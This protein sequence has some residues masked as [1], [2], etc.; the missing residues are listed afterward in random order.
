MKKKL[1]LVAMSSVLALGV[2]GACGDVDEEPINDDP[3]L[4]NNVDNDMGTNT[5][6][7]VND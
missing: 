6:V 2:L 1:M 7:E 5:E 4:E 3:V